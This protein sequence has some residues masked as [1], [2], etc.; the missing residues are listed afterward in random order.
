MEV[1]FSMKTLINFLKESLKI[2]GIF[3]EPTTAEIDATITFLALPVPQTQH[4]IELVKVYAPNASLRDKPWMN[5]RIGNHVPPG[6]GNQILPKLETI[7]RLAQVGVNPHY[8][9]VQYELLHPFTDGNGRSGRTLWLWQMNG[10]AP[11]GFL[12]KF[13]YQTLDAAYKRPYTPSAAD[14]VRID[15][16]TMTLLAPSAMTTYSAIEA[17]DKPHLKVF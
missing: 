12:H 17:E 1:G 9:H 14:V 8:V 16:G 10:K 5:V 3:R 4:V 15:A 6:G 7:L 13:Y 11:L 2:E